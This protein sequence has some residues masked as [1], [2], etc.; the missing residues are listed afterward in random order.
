MVS[1]FA[2][3]RG[4]ITYEIYVQYLLDLLEQKHLALRGQL[5]LMFSNSIRHQMSRNTC[6]NGGTS[7]LVNLYLFLS[8][9]SSNVW[10]TTFF[11]GS[12]HR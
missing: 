9:S 4:N 6:F 3:L 5:C 12:A 1:R 8:L 7:S 2:L 10:T 11:L